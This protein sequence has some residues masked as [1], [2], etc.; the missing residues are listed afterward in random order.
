MLI[1]EKKVI[2][3]RQT[4]IYVPEFYIHEMQVS[5]AIRK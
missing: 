4:I 1:L 5:S 3:T 2:L